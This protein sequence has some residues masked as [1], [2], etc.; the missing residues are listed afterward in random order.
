MSKKNKIDSIYEVVR[1]LFIGGLSALT[2]FTVSNLTNLIFTISF[3]SASLG[4]LMSVL[5]SYFGHMKITYRVQPNHKIMGWKFIVLC[6]IN[7]LYTNASTYT[8]HDI[9]G[10]EYLVASGFVV[11]TLPFI[12]YPIGKFWVFKEKF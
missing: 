1:Y 4:W 11:V 5:V 2:Y 10:F 6:A 9:I 12:L 8:V 3:V 7:L